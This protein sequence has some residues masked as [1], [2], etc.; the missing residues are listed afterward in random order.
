MKLPSALALAALIAMSSA[1]LDDDQSPL[2]GRE[3]KHPNY[4]VHLFSKSPLVIYLEGFLTK[5]EREHM[6]EVAYATPGP[7]SRPSFAFAHAQKSLY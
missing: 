1:S 2:E 5:E 7:R 3:C 4:K 6:L